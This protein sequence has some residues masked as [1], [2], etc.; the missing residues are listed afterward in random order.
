MGKTIREHATTINYDKEYSENERNHG[1]DS[2]IDREDDPRLDHISQGPE[3]MEEED[4]ID[5]DDGREDHSEGDDRD[6]GD[7]WTGGIL[8][9]E[10]SHDR[11]DDYD[12]YDEYGSGG[13]RECERG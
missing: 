6:D 9:E 7:L 12:D 5:Y 10:E 13:L 2:Q 11:G 3:L 8:S 4:Y 1:E